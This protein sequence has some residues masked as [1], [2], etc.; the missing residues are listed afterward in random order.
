MPSKRI[1]MQDIADACGLSRNTV[2]KVYNGRG[3]VPQATRNLVL[4]K[5]KELGYGAPAEDQ[6]AP[7]RSIGNIALLTRFLPSQLHFGTLF[8]SSFTDL[9]SRAGYTLKIYE[10]SSEELSKKQLPPHFSAE[11]VAGI[12]GIELFDSQ[13]VAML[14]RLGIP[15]VMTDSSPDSI[16]SLIECDYVTMENI[17]AVMAVIN[18][19]A[20]AGARHIGF[21]GDYNHCG[22]FRERWYGFQQGLLVNG[23]KFDERYCICEPDSPSYSDSSWLTS[24]LDRMP[25]MPDAFVCAND[26]LAIPLL[27]TLKKRGLSIP[28][29]IMITGFDGSAQSAFTDPPLTTVTIH[30]SEI[31][32]LA[33][34]Q[35][36]NRIRI[37]SFPYS[38]THVKSTPVWR[39][40]I[41][42][43]QDK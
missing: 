14:C 8:L 19:L 43:I 6:S 40:S 21:V 42:S 5:A 11:Q 22:S 1:T 3:S 24:R 32:R 7:S 36:L 12:V 35:L 25:S 9:I 28:R 30:G 38:W 17:A 26:Y 27:L 33:A 2:S 10:V 37:P 18:R 4:Q 29:D 20:G 39:E 31:G 15:V 34:E 16:T 23:L 41:R 13:Y